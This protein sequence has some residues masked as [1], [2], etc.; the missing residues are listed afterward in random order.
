MKLASAIVALIAA[1]TLVSACSTDWG[2]RVD[3]NWGS[4][5]HDNTEA[6][7]ANP[8]GSPAEHDPGR[9]TDGVS[10]ELAARKLRESSAGKKGGGAPAINLVIP[11]GGK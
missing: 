2:S 1:G 4:A 7:I 10:E 11:I 3:R 5:V 9:D 8:E 6:M